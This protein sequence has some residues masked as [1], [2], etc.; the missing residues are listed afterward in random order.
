[1]INRRKKKNKRTYLNAEEL[2]EL[3]I[4]LHGQKT[5][6]ERSYELENMKI[7]MK[8]LKHFTK[9]D[10]DELRQIHSKDWRYK[11][12]FSWFW[13]MMPKFIALIGSLLLF[14]YWFGVES[15]I[16]FLP[17]TLLLSVMLSFIR[18]TRGY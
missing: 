4:E 12:Y 16:A 18:L 11:I 2:N 14:T 17:I 6:S 1:M 3:V 8:D 13:D 9:E 7:K 15:L 5:R 10:I